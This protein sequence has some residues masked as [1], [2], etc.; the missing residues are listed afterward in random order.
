MWFVDAVDKHHYAGETQ[1][2]QNALQFGQQFIT[3][4]TAIA[5]WHGL[6]VYFVCRKPRQNSTQSSSP[7]FQNA[8]L[9]GNLTCTPPQG[10]ISSRPW[11]P[12]CANDCIQPRCLQNAQSSQPDLWQVAESHAKC[13]QCHHSA[14]DKPPMHTRCEKPQTPLDSFP[15]PPVRLIGR[16]VVE[17]RQHQQ[18]TFAQA[19]QFLQLLQTNVRIRCVFVGDHVAQS[20]GG[21]RQ[22]RVH[23]VPQPPR[24]KCVVGMSLSSAQS[25]AERIQKR[26]QVVV[27]DHKRPLL[28][29]LLIIFVDRVD[30]LQTNCRFAGTL[31]TE[32]NRSGRVGAVTQHFVPRR[33]INCAGAVLLKNMIRLGVF[34]T[35]RINLDAVVFK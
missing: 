32:D 3:V 24:L 12:A 14:D 21:Q 5:R 10:Q 20:P 6:P 15:A 9:S 8:D 22:Q 23:V 2:L 18:I 31:F 17:C 16:L 34:L 13:C 7:V 29:L 4:I 25:I 27:T 35:E 1:G 28:W 30:Q 19:R 33:M 26:I 11:Q